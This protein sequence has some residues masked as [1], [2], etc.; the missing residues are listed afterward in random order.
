MKKRICEMTREE[1]KTALKEN[2]IAKNLLEIRRLELQNRIMEL[3]APNP[4]GPRP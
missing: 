4:D 2:A 1:A 3:P